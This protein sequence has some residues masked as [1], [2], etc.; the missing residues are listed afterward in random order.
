MNGRLSRIFIA[1]ILLA[2]VALFT[3]SCSIKTTCGYS[4]KEMKH[5]HKTNWY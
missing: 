1:I 5:K 4:K 3:V 2:S